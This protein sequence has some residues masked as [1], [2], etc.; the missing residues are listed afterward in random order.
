MPFIKMVRDC[1]VYMKDK[2]RD[3]GVN[4]FH[5]GPGVMA[6]EM[7]RVLPEVQYAS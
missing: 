6:D 4:A 1:I 2:Y 5:G 3:D 7:K